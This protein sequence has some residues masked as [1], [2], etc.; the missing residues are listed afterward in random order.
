MVLLAAAAVVV[1]G[2]RRPADLVANS[3]EGVVQRYLHAISD[4]D[5]AAMQDT[6]APTM[7]ERCAE[8]SPLP[9]DRRPLEADLVA[10]RV[11]D[12]DTVDVEVR[13]TE[14]SGGPPFGATYD[15]TEVFVTERTD[16]T[17]LIADAP[18]PYLECRA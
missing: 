9:Q 18:W 6:F 8:P 10:T 5:R 14:F 17:W 3:P 15:Y 12:D 4:A 16:G 11:V 2:A 7:R 13:I 1:S